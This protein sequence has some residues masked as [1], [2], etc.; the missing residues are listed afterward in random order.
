MKQTVLSTYVH[1]KGNH[2]W[3]AILN[4][5]SSIRDVYSLF[6]AK[7]NH[8]SRTWASRSSIQDAR[9]LQLPRF[10]SNCE[11]GRNAAYFCIL[12]TRKIARSQRIHDT[13]ALLL[14]HSFTI[15]LRSFTPTTWRMRVNRRR[16]EPVR[17][18]RSV[19][20]GHMLYCEMLMPMFLLLTENRRTS[21]IISRHAAVALGDYGIR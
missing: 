18:N 4:S 6:R 13:A 14:P 3:R 12:D 21:C 1:Q 19:F 17:W 7:S 2:A 5:F 16:R 8:V 15:P 9:S 20:E 11:I 10:D